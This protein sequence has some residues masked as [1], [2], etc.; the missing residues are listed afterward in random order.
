MITYEPKEKVI[1]VEEN[2]IMHGKVV[3]T[4]RPYSS[5]HTDDKFQASFSL[6]C[7]MLAIGYGVTR[8]DAI[9]NALDN[10]NKGVSDAFCRITELH[11]AIE[12]GE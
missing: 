8:Q 1:D 12:A 9:G 6:P 7:Y 10:A 4:M 5:E 2:I 3:G 11:L